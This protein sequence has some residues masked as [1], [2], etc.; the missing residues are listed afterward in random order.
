MK[1]R[2]GFA[3]KIKRALEINELMGERDRIE[4][5]GLNELDVREVGRILFY[6]ETEI[7]LSL[8]SYILKICGRDLYCV[9]FL[10]AVIRVSGEIE[11][12]EF[13]RRNKK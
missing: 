6:S 13:D 10:G 2:D 3:K 1:E 5:V 12:L 9:S 8:R 4:M 11:S 7:R